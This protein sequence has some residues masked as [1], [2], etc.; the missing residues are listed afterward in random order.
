MLH[1]RTQAPMNRESNKQLVCV[2]NTNIYHNLIEPPL[3]KEHAS[4]MYMPTLL[5]IDCRSITVKLYLY[6]YTYM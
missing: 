2:L 4:Y 6:Q 1:V 5:P 3:A